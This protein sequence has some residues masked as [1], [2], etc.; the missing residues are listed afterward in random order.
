MPRLPRRRSEI[1][2]YH[3][4]NRGV[5][6]CIIYEDDRDCE[7]FLEIVE[8]VMEK[9]GALLLAWCLM[10][11]HYHILTQAAFEDLPLIMHAI[12]MAYARYFNR[13]YERDGCLFG[14]RYKSEP[15]ESDE[16]FL[17]VLRYIHRN[18]VKA[19]IS[20]TCDYRWSSFR[21]YVETPR[22]INADLAFSMISTKEEFRRFHE[23]DDPACACIDIDRNRGRQRLSDR[24]ALEIARGVLRTCGVEKIAGLMRTA[25]DEA[26]R[27]LKAVRLSVRQIS[28]F[29]GIPKSIVARA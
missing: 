17:T 3:L 23:I 6:H 28:R 18:P 25:R 12:N 9:F 4:M 7:Q 8:S 2:I 14:A 10:D 19:R 24:E 29:T 16:H 13:R 11:N 27:T 15:V 1:N 22:L 21:E 5:G 26:L 20:Q